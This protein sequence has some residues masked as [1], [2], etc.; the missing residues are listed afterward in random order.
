MT[1]DR[2]GDN[3]PKDIQM[4]LF[5]SEHVRCEMDIATVK[6]LGHIINHLQNNVLP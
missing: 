3:V 4:S 6:L 5:M 1:V 2:E